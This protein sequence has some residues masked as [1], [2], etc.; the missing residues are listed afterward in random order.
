MR[1]WAMGLLCS[2]A[3]AGCGADSPPAEPTARLAISTSATAPLLFNNG[4]GVPVGLPGGVGFGLMNG[5]TVALV[6]QSATYVGAPA[7]TLT[8]RSS[9]PATL[10]FNQELVVDLTCTPPATNT[11]DGVVNIASNAVNLPMA[12]VFVSCVGTP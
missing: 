2:L 1:A 6:V 8:T 4:L 3:I 10:G 7:I 12:E 5:G 11:Y 9:L